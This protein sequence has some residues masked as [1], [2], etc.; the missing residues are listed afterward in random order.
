MSFDGESICI[1][2]SD[3]RTISAPLVWYPRLYH[4]SVQERNNWKLIGK[5][6]GIHWPEL[7]EDLSIESIIIGRPSM[8]NAGSLEK[9]L[10][11]RKG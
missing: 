3:G 1:S 6:S 9:W 2:L 8:E 4:G 11:S 5:G 7:N 10:K